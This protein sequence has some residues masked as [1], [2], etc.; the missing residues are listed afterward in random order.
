MRAAKQYQV[1][2]LGITLSEQ[3]YYETKRRI[4][5]VFSLQVSKGNHL[6]YS[7][8]PA[9]ITAI[10]LDFFLTCSKKSSVQALWIF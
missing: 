7:T 1:N 10:L 2:V 3:Q 5:K 6:L 8:F 4:Q 9:S